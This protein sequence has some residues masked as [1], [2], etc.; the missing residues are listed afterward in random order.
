M[1]YFRYKIFL[2]KSYTDVSVIFCFNF[3]DYRRD[4]SR[5]VNSKLMYSMV[6]EIT[7][8]PFIKKTFNRGEDVL[9]APGFTPWFDVYMK[10]YLQSIPILEHE[11]I[12]NHLGVIFAVAAN[13]SNP[14]ETLKNLSQ[15][16]YRQQHENK[17]ST[18][19]QYISTNVLKYYVL[20]RL[21]K[22]H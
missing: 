15:L 17:S 11:F 6:A 7:D 2:Q 20:V 8:E 4:P 14:V 5:Q 1:S 19:P 18:Y 22:T 13:N 9:E 21:L 3:K 12:R 10:L 16:Q